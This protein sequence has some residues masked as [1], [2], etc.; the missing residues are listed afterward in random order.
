[1][2]RRF[3]HL[4]LA[5]ALIVASATA[6]QAHTGVGHTAGFLHGFAH[7]FSGLDHMLAMVAVGLF[8]ARL[9]GR[10]LWLVPATFVAMMAVGGAWGISGA[11]LPF[12]ELGIAASVIALGM[13]VA[14]NASM[15]VAVA[16]GLVGFFAVFHGHAHGTEM[17]LDASGA[18]YAAGF[19]AATAVLHATG[20]AAGISAARFAAARSL[21]AAQ[22]AGG[23][24]ALAGFGLLTGVI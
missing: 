17:P 24:M 14:L 6:A 9:G 21:R 7:P 22:V 20:L 3:N 18:S 8:A 2:A 15:A 10:A 1:M 11:S 23:A 12:V 16:M 19:M 13:V 4:A 5:G